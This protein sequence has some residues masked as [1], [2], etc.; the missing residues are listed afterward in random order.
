MMNRRRTWLLLFCGLALVSQAQVF[1]LVHQPGLE[2]RYT[3]ATFTSAGNWMVVGHR[4]INNSFFSTAV[5]VRLST[6]GETL[7][8]HGY[9]FPGH[10]LTQFSCI[11]EL[12]TDTF[13]VAGTTSF[14]CDFGPFLGLLM[15][16]HDGA[17]LWSRTYGGEDGWTEFNLMAVG[18]STIMLPMSDGL[19]ITA[20]DGDSLTWVQTGWSYARSMRTVD[21]HFL[22]AGYAGL[23]RFDQQGAAEG[24]WTDAVL[25]DVAGHPD[26]GYVAVG[27]TGVMRFDAAL[28]QVGP[29][30]ALDLP[31][32][33]SHRSITWEDGRF[34]VIDDSLLHV[35]D[36]DLNVLATH[37]I[38][39][40]D[41][42]GPL[43]SLVADGT[44]FTAGWF[45]CGAV[46]AAVRAFSVE[47]LL[48]TSMPDIALRGVSPID[49]SYTVYPNTLINYVNGTF[50]AGAWV[51]NH[52]ADPVTRATLNQYLP[53]GICGPA[54]ASY[55]L[56]D[57]VLPPGDSVW[58]TQG[59]FYLTAYVDTGLTEVERE[60][61]LWV[62]S[63]NNR[64][65]A[66]RVD[67]EA[68]ATVTIL[69][70]AKELDPLRSVT[71]YPNPFQGSITIDGLPAGQPVQLELRDAVGRIVHRSENLAS[72]GPRM[73]QPSGLSAGL[74]VL[75]VRAGGYQR[76]L[77]LLHFD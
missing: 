21:S 10:E 20:L 50:H 11:A 41:G 26:G 32:D 8:E 46:G 74:Y 40:P 76:D 47:G 23:Q 56:N 36:E 25:F 48:P 9:A 13:L 69:L 63:A 55:P 30:V 67:N 54:G 3:G 73:L 68:C 38:G 62:A 27:Q 71:A 16:W 45:N 5:L 7:E 12:G 22:L 49:L 33:G 1:D 6:T 65:D 39:H 35:L 14:G 2:G 29:L 43:T 44:A 18:D 17:P 66:Q 64:L 24:S 70:S 57:L 77:R 58:I 52:G 59:P 42:Y 31:S 51:V 19:L 34:H 61:C 53:W 15:A 60:V 28:Q 72:T 4:P 37:V 75:Q